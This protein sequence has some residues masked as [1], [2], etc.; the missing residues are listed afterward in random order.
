VSLDV[1]IIDS[2]GANLASLQFALERLGAQALVTSDMAVIAAAPRVLLPGVGSALA[3]MQ[4]LT[5]SGVAAQ[6]PRLKQPV[7]GICLGMQLLFLKS[8]E[9]PAQCLGVLPQTVRKLEP[10]A[11]RPVPHMGWNRLHIAHPDP[12][13]DGVAEGEYVYF[14]HSYAAPLSQN[15]LASAGY[16]VEI[17]AVVRKDN[18]WGTQFHPERS[19]KAGARILAN[20]LRLT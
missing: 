18:F 12:L 19:T 9:G 5:A 13:L 1:A 4:R 16:G 11:G 7:L 15:T 10:T 17:A 3:A 6:L 2:G 14:V 20:F 8:E